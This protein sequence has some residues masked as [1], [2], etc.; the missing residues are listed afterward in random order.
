M[1]SRI[2]RTQTPMPIIPMLQRR[3]VRLYAL[4][5]GFILFG[6]GLMDYFGS[7]LPMALCGSAGL[8]LCAPLARELGER[9]FGRASR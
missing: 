3:T 4:G 8:M 2:F 7:V 5:Q 1:G 6:A 9:W